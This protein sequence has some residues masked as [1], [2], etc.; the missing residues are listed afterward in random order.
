MH[1]IQHDL[2]SPS[3]IMIAD[4]HKLFNIV[5]ETEITWVTE[6]N[7]MRTD[8]KYVHTNIISE[9]W[10]NL[11]HFYE[12]VFGCE[13]VLPERNMFGTWIEDGTG[14]PNAH[15]RGAHLRL[16]GYGDNGPTLEIFQYNI[17]IH[18]HGKKINET[19]LVHIAFLVDDVAKT[20]KEVVTNGGSQ[21]G[22]IVIKEI[23]E[24]GTLTF[25]YTRD[26]DG[27]IVELQSWKK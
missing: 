22:K 2:L 4:Q 3:K 6:C 26:P 20:L 23:A 1:E 25:V 7:N 21:L 10:E 18:G 14:V 13:R 19:G 24:V 12:T 16:P 9:D 11:A 27:N 15:V 17:G 5:R 8:A